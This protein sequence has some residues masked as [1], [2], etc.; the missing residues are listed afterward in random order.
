M[1]NKVK[2]FQVVLEADISEE[3]AADF[4]RALSLMRG[5]ATV[6]AVESAGF[7]DDVIR[8]RVEMEMVQKLAALARD[9]TEG[10][11]NGG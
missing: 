10:K 6:T 5:V 11:R 2:G 3:A 7:T 1:A 4:M 8:R 9:L